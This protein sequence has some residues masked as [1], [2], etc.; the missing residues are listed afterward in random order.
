MPW[1]LVRHGGGDASAGHVPLN[2]TPLRG[3]GLG[4]AEEGF[5][6][7]LWASAHVDAVPVRGT[8]T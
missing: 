7:S 2:R 8:P 5:V 4:I 6:E 3:P 1:A